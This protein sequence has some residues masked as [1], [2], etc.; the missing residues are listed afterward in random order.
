MLNG[1]ISPYHYR[2]TIKY[3]NFEEISA[4]RKAQGILEGFVWHSFS[5]NNLSM[6][7][8]G[9]VTKGKE[10]IFLHFKSAS[11]IDGYEILIC[12]VA[13]GPLAIFW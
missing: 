6:I 3:W 10:H 9:L 8:F 4:A 13:G 11:K 2:A 5:V 12:W 1:I 7:T